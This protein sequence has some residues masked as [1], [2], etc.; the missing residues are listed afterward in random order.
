M[1]PLRVLG[2]LATIVFAVGIVAGAAIAPAPD[3]S[4]ADS[5]SIVQRA[6]ALLVAQA[7]SSQPG[8]QAPPGTS[9]TAGATTTATVGAGTSLDSGLKRTSEK[10][11]TPA[12]SESSSSPSSAACCEPS[13]GRSHTGAG[14]AIQKPPRL[15]PIQHVWLVML[16]GSTLA[17]A[18]A[19][20]SGYPYLA[21]RLVEQGTLLTS[22]SALDSY[23]LAGDATLLPGGVGASLDVISEPGCDGEPASATGAPACTQAAPASPAEA[24]Q[25]L[26]RVVEPIV[27]GPAY[28]EN[29]LVVVTFAGASQSSGVPATTL[30]LQPVAGALLLSP[31]LHGG[32]RNSTPFDSLSPRTSLAMIFSH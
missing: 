9:P 1:P 4:L 3:S 24:D 19:T 23:E 13:S 10:T 30:A 31:L 21:G 20:P 22:Y 25:F 27:S 14:E 11:P 8:A 32:T 2:A 18:T 15:P 28:R 26:Q 6:I 29:G 17:S 16:S 5:P 12:T 7:A